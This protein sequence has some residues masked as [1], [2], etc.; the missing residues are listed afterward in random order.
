[1]G[2]GRGAAVGA[3]LDGHA[4]GNPRRTPGMANSPSPHA[5]DIRAL[6][7]WPTPVPL[8]PRTRGL[9][10]PEF[11]GTVHDPASPD[12]RI[13]TL[14]PTTNPEFPF[15]HTSTQELGGTSAG[16]FGCC[17][18]SMCESATYDW[19]S[20]DER[21]IVKQAGPAAVTAL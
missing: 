19:S 7:P 2:R 20:G 18:S 17:V 1:M 6:P 5:P 14:L 11:V 16:Q 15:F 10:F 4:M 12:C 9:R 21:R 13:S 3:P 8:V